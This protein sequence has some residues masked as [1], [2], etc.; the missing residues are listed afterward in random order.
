MCIIYTLIQITNG[1]ETSFAYVGVLDIKIG[2]FL[3]GQTIQKKKSSKHFIV[4]KYTLWIQ[5][6]N[7]F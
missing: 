4:L 2:V 7:G 3:P 6:M 5:I 1:S